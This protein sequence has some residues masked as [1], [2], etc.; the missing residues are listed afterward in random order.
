MLHLGAPLVEYVCDQLKQHL[1]VPAAP[2]PFSQ[3]HTRQLKSPNRGGLILTGKD[4]D[5]WRLK[6]KPFNFNQDND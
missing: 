4:D 2:Q 3:Y 1:T 5:G 6:N